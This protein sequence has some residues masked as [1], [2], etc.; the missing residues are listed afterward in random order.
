MDPLV[1][2]Q[3]KNAAK[4]L[5][6]KYMQES[7]TAVYDDSVDGACV[8]TFKIG[9]Y[10]AKRLAIKECE[11]VLPTLIGFTEM[12]KSRFFILKV[13]HDDLVKTLSIGH[14]ELVK[15]IEGLTEYDLN[16]TVII[17]QN[18]KTII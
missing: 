14:E 4:K 6:K 11:I 8:G 18:D 15:Q 17:N 13:Q 1:T 9:F 12:M 2:L 16:E 5:V 7:I 10:D 3:C